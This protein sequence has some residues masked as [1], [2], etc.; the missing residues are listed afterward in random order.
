VIGAPDEPV[1]PFIV[2]NTTGWSSVDIGHIFAGAADAVGLQVR[3]GTVLN[4]FDQIS[5]PGHMKI[6]GWYKGLATCSVLTWSPTT[7][8]GAL[9]AGSGLPLDELRKL[10]L[11]APAILTRGALL[12]SPK[13]IVADPLL[14]ECYMN[15]H[16]RTLTNPIGRTGKLWRDANVD[17]WRG[18]LDSEVFAVECDQPEVFPL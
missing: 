3:S 12:G 7:P 5:A 11:L 16:Y 14:H 15:G 1:G 6:G 17:E 9:V 8:L 13:V 4:V 10:C 2:R 18:P